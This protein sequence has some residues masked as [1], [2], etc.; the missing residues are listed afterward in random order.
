MHV[1]L[2]VVNFLTDNFDRYR[3]ISKILSRQT[4]PLIC[5][6]V[7]VKDSTTPKPC[8]CANLWFIVKH[9]TCFRVLLFFWC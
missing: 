4:Q 3:L 5:N 1:V 2:E 7:L 9:C 8:C 6:K